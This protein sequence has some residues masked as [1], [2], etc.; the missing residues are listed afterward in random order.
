MSKNHDVSF[1]YFKRSKITKRFLSE[2]VRAMRNKS[3]LVI[4]NSL[5]QLHL[6]HHLTIVF[7]AK[8]NTLTLRS[9]Q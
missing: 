8:E 6:K 9:T 2:F 3:R 4:Y 7:L 1:K 5:R